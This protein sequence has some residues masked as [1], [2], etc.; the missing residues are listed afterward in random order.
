MTIAG[1]VTN[2]DAFGLTVLGNVRN[3]ITRLMSPAR[4]KHRNVSRGASKP[5]SN[6][7]AIALTQVLKGALCPS[8]FVSLCDR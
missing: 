7:K 5:P 8:F 2:D 3:H 1:I 4:T 6:D